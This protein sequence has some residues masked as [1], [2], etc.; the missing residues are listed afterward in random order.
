[1]CDSC[2]REFFKVWY[3]TQ[4]AITVYHRFKNISQLKFRGIL[5]IGSTTCMLSFTDHVS[6]FMRLGF[7]LYISLQTNNHFC[8]FRP[9]QIWVMISSN[10]NYEYDLNQIWDLVWFRHFWN[11][12]TFAMMFSH[13]LGQHS[14]YALLCM[15]CTA[16]QIIDQWL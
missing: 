1:M 9:D 10:M 15:I 11:Y 12:P 16:C 4:W 14:R 6:L 7:I 8:V 5:I 13:L 2:Y 3:K